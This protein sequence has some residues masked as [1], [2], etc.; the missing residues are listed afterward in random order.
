MADEVKAFRWL[1]EDPANAKQEHRRL[2][3]MRHIQLR[4]EVE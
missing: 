1:L 4:H 3:S 2:G